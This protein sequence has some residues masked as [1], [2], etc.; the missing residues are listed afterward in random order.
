[1]AKFKLGDTVI[2]INSNEK[3]VVTEVCPPTRGRQLYKISIVNIIRNCLETNLMADIDLSDPFKRLE[4]GIFG[5]FLDF[6]RLNTSFKIK[7]TSNNSISTL[8][9]SNTI[10][11]AYQ[12]KPLL[13]FLNSENKRILVADEV[14]SW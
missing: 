9:A 13:K 14:G 1:M 12:F 2:Y 4:Q 11:K 10:F 3:G 7:N 5:S 6:S 8:K